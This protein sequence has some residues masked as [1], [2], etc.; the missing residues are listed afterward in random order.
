MASKNK[1]NTVAEEKKNLHIEN[2]VDNKTIVDSNKSQVGHT[3]I[4]NT[5]LKHDI[6]E[7]SVVKKPEKKVKIDLSKVIDFGD[8]KKLK[9]KKKIKDVTPL[10]DYQKEVCETP[11]T[12]KTKPKS[13][14]PWEDIK[15][16]DFLDKNGFFVTA[17][18]ETS[19]SDV[20]D[21]DLSDFDSSDEGRSSGYDSGYEADI[22]EPYIIEPKLAEVEEE[23]FVPINL[24]YSLLL[25]RK[26][27]FKYNNIV[28]VNINFLLLNYVNY[29]FYRQNWL[30]LYPDSIQFKLAARKYRYKL[31]KYK[32]RL[33][34]SKKVRFEILGVRSIVQ[35]TSRYRNKFFTFLRKSLHFNLSVGRV[36]FW[37]LKKTVF[38]RILNFYNVFFRC[39]IPF[40]SRRFTILFYKLFKDWSGD[41]QKFNGAI[42][43]AKRRRKIR[44]T[45]SVFKVLIFPKMIYGFMR[46]AKYPIR[47]RFLQRRAFLK[48]MCS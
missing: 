3:T 43:R 38:G 34:Y 44:R 33:Y 37:K 14:G 29:L 30:L 21:S 25:K 46:S 19:D 28:A 23:D 10:L 15:D 32:N 40:L 36:P 8:L 18:P 6:P 22:D 9:K 5:N 31:N 48:Y 24:E 41:F 13:A 16:T 27:R 4:N 26:K 47:K 12:N 20:S 35:L 2:I 45:Y 17:Y 39:I 1:K 42:L 7:K 11:E